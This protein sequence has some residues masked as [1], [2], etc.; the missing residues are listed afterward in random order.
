VGRAYYSDNFVDQDPKE[1]RS[2]PVIIEV[3]PIV[4]K[5][6]ETEVPIY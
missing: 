6:Q 3:L 4:A 2:A 1:V 5:N